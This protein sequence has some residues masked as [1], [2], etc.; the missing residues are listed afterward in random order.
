MKRFL[1]ASHGRMASG[2]KNSLEILTGITEGIVA[3]DAYLDGSDFL[4]QITAFFEQATR[5]ETLLI[6]TDL[7]GGSVNQKIFAESLK[8]P[9]L[10]IHIITG[11]NLSIV[12][13]LL[14]EESPLTASR[15][16]ELIQQ[17]QLKL[18]ESSLADTQGNDTEVFFN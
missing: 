4:P 17:S 12:L 16:T 11:M 2:L 14:L 3:I 18:L 7:Y 8:F 6:F 5:S 1:L 9:E 13:A 15:L 10:K